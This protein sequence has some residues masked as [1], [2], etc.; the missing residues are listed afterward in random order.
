MSDL[1]KRDVG[2][3]TVITDA[4]LAKLEI[5]FS[6]GASDKEACKL[7]NINPSTLYKYQER[8]PEF[9]ERKA[10]LKDMV[11]WQA[12]YNIAEAVIDKKDLNWS[13]W[14]AERKARGEFGT[15][16]EH[17]NVNIETT[18]DD[19]EKEMLTNLLNGQSKGT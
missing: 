15:R 3:P 18:L 17:V 10:E 16:T 9:V 11:T 5:A 19:E 12:K 8:C 13:A 14:W 2:R 1:S 6:L 7:A 4:T